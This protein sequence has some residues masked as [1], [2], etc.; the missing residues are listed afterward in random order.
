MTLDTP[1]T[2]SPP[3]G[4][5]TYVTAEAI[6]RCTPPGSTHQCRYFHALPYV[7]AT[8]HELRSHNLHWL[9]IAIRRLC[10][11]VSLPVLGLL[12]RSQCTLSDPRR[13]GRE[14]PYPWNREAEGRTDILSFLQDIYRTEAPGNRSRPVPPGGE[15]SVVKR[16]FANQGRS[17]GPEIAATRQPIT[18]YYGFVR[19][20]AKR[21]DTRYYR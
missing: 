4:V 12:S 14:R 5:T 19:T 11:K 3:F 15:R 7:D 9:R 13:M 1:H 20:R 16:S 8:A 6:P 17:D 2:R 21:V 18:I 10:V